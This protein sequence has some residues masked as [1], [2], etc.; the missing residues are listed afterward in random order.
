VQKVTFSGE[1]MEYHKECSFSTD[2]AGNVTAGR[3]KL[4]K[5]GEWQY[6]CEECREELERRLKEKDEN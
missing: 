3:G 4:D 1:V 6:P 2:I 5:Y